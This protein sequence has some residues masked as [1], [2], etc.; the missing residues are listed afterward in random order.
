MDLD[1]TPEEKAEWLEEAA[2]AIRGRM[3]LHGATPTEAAAQLSTQRSWRSPDA[4]QILQESLTEILDF[5]NVIR[6]PTDWPILVDRAM[7]ADFS[8]G[9]SANEYIRLYRSLV[10]E[11]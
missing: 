2:D 8:W 9:R 4:A 5:I 7:R 3:K 11:G 10:K 6:K 1:L